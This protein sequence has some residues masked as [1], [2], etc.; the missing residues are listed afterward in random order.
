MTEASTASKLIK[1]YLN[2]S[3]N[4]LLPKDVDIGFG[5]RGIMQQL[6][7]TAAQKL[8]FYNGCRQ[9]YVAV[10]DKLMEKSPLNF[11]VVRGLV[12]LDPRF[13]V[14]HPNWSVT[15]F[16]AVLNHLSMC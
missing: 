1:V 10:A 15:K 9:I 7:V 14:A 2:N 16:T 12:D 11:V 13:I 4:L 5:A 6:V 8:E 3:D